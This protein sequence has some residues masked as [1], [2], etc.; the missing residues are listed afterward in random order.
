MD[1]PNHWWLRWRSCLAAGWA[2]FMIVGN[3]HLLAQPA[4][5]WGGTVVADRVPYQPQVLLDR[6]AEDAH[7]VDFDAEIAH[8]EAL[9]VAGLTT[10]SVPPGDE[11]IDETGPQLPPGT[12][13]GVFQKLLFTGTWLPQLED[14]S[15]GWG[16]LEA[17][18]VFGFPFLRRDT[19][20]LITP[21]YAVH[22]LDGA[23]TFDLPDQ[24]YDASIEFRHMRKFGAGPWAMDV[25]VTLGHYSDY[26]GDDDDAFRVSGRG[27]GVYEAQPGVK[28]LLGVA[29]LN[30][31]GASVLPVVGV[32]YDPNPSV[33]YEL[34]FPR[35]R[36]AWQLPWSDPQ[37]GDERWAYIAGEFGGG[38][39]SIER[40][41]SGMH[42]L[43]TYSDVRIIAGYERKIIGGLTRRF[44]VGYVFAREL[45][46]ESATPDVDLDDTL[47]ARLGLTY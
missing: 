23:E 39:W 38:V 26:E 11:V 25:A 43:L 17:G 36:V 34:I 2:L 14:D 27:I 45:E 40:P 13:S 9:R 4:A 33:S 42:D 32:I 18:V 6:W 3:S 19:P 46:F 12:R 8:D 7:P 47:F 28:W 37:N 29:Y 10:D 31:A 5:Q 30:R 21:R 35:P 22:F 16:D 24:V 20:L 41:S 1:M 15:L 44:E